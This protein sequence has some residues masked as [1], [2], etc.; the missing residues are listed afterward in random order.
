MKHGIKLRKLGR[1]SSHR[2]A[3]LRN[4]VAAL[5]HHEQIQTTVPKAKE[6]ARVAEK[7]I[8]LGKKGTEMAKRSAQAM[9]MPAH[10]YGVSATPLP[11][12]P[13]SPNTTDEETT[14]LLPKLF[15]TLAS[16]YALRSGGYTR[17]TKFGH[18]P[19]DN[20]PKCILSLVDSERDVKYEMAARSV[21]RQVVDRVVGSGKG[22]E[23]VSVAVREWVGEVVQEKRGKEVTGLLSDKTRLDVGKVLKLKSA[24]EVDA[25]VQA[26]TQY[27]YEIWALP[28]ATRDQRAALEQ[29]T[30]SRNRVPPCV[31]L[32]NDQSST[33]NLPSLPSLQIKS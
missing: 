18:R 27:A 16:R 33:L 21:G 10:H 1:T 26:A 7:M 29:T 6:A 13:I 19:G 2:S 12:A 25:F 22:R 11:K 4:L 24:E 28:I 20:A 3:L 9:L 14:S 31:F 30:K 32:H 17:I 5:L 15:T 8:T 23:G